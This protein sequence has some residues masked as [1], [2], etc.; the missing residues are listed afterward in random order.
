MLKKIHLRVLAFSTKLWIWPFQVVLLRSVAKISAKL[1]NAH[2]MVQGIVFI[3]QT[4][5]F[6][7]FLLPF[8]VIVVRRMYII[9]AYG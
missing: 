9:Q 3:R 7:V 8:A 1:K 6:V 2:A 5:C 4:Y